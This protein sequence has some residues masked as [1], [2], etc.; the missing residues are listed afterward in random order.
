VV[1]QNRGKWALPVGTVDESVQLEAVARKGDFLGRSE[2]DTV[3]CHQRCK[4]QQKS[5]GAAPRAKFHANSGQRKAR[6]EVIRK[7]GSC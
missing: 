6:K 5:C 3:R 2:A 7:F 4:D 1:V